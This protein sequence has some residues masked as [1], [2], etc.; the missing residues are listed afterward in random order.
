M[1]KVR[2]IAKAIGARLEGDGDVA[3]RRPASPD[4]AGPNDLALAMDPRYVDAL[5][6]SGCAAAVLSNGTDWQALG[7]KAAIFVERPRYAMAHVTGFFATPSEPD[8]I[9]DT[10]IIHPDA[11]IDAGA[12]IAPFV[13]IG[14]NAKIGANARIN[15]HV[16][17]GPDV[18]IGEN[19]R[20]ADGVRIMAGTVIGS[21]VII[22]ANA[23]IGSDGFSF[24][25]PQPGNVDAFKATGTVEEQTIDQDYARIHS[26]GAVRLGNNVEIGAGT[27]IDRGTVADTVIGDGTK[28]DN[29]VHIGHNVRI[30]RTCLICG[31][32]GIAGSAVIGDRVVLAGQVGVADHVVVGDD[33][34]AAGKS[35]ISSNV[36]PNR[37]IMGNPAVRMEANVESYKA[38]RRL[39]RLAAKLEALEKQVSKF[40]SNG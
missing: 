24:V 28:I 39:P 15:A 34:I 38:F 6:A 10:A 7:L 12:R 8:G 11:K 25:T 19:A 22:H 1:H 29:L 2:D 17:I 16:S 23:V 14:P 9:H 26:L 33:V 27:T 32:V 36:P 4:N 30:G 40:T 35:G 18:T 13:V 3:V 37:A 21:D 31:Q 5:R 20:I